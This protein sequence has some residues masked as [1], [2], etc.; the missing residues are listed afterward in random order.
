MS[1]GL[2]SYFLIMTFLALC[3]SNSFHR[4][5]IHSAR[6]N[7]IMKLLVK[8]VKF[9]SVL[10]GIAF[11]SAD[12]SASR[13]RRRTPRGTF[14]HLLAPF[15]TGLRR[16]RGVHRLRVSN[17]CHTFDLFG[18]PAD[19]RRLFR[20]LGAHLPESPERF[21]VGVSS[22]CHHLIKFNS[23]LAPLLIILIA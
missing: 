18:Q 21:A 11:S 6:L 20:C 16:A 19:S 2:Y 8:T 10:I 12:D 13:H 23:R 4:H 15:G 22:V 14:W 1:Q 9:V 5:T 17:E 3:S 7:I